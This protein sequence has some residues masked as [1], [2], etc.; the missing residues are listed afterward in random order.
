MP[1]KRALFRTEPL[2]GPGPVRDRVTVAIG[3]KLQRFPWRQLDGDAKVT[4]AD[5]MD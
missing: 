5:F 4:D 1:V 3:P 2:E